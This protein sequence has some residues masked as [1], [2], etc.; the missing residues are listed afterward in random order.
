MESTWGIIVGDAFFKG[1]I[2]MDIV[3]LD[4]HFRRIWRSKLSLDSYPLDLKQ[5][6]EELHED[7]LLEYQD[8]F[9]LENQTG[10]KRLCEDCNNSTYATQFCEFCIRNYLIQTFDKWDSGNDKINKLIQ[11]TQ[12]NVICP[13]QVVEWIPYENFDNINLLDQGGFSTVFTA[14]WENGYFNEWNSITKSLERR[15]EPQQIVLKQLNSSTDDSWLNEKRVQRLFAEAVIGGMRPDINMGIP[16]KYKTLM[17]QCWDADPVKRPD[18]LKIWQREIL[19]ISKEP[20]FL[21]EDQKLQSRMSTSCILA[22]FKNSLKPINTSPETSNIKSM[23]STYGIIVGDAFFKGQ[24]TTDIVRLDKHFRRIWRSKLS[25]DSYPLDLKQLCEEL[26]KEFRNDN[27]LKVQEKEYLESKLLEYQDKFNLENQ[28]GVKRLC[29]DCNNST[30]ATQFCEFCIRNYLMQ[31]FDKWDSGNDKIN[32]IIQE[33]QKN[34][35]CPY[36]VV[37]WIP[38]ENFDNVKMLNKGGFSTVFT[39]TWKNGY[40]NR[41]NSITKSLERRG[42]PQQIVLKELYSRKPNDSWLNEKRVQR[43]FAE[44][45]IGG[46]RPDI[47]IGIPEK[48][49][50][51]MQQCWDADPVKRPD[52]LTIW[53]KIRELRRDFIDNGNR[54]FENDILNISK[55]HIIL[56]KD[57]TLQSRMSTSCILAPFQDSSKPINVSPGQYYFI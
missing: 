14:T 56:S 1:Q 34:V 51:L 13:Y 28:T 4:K 5:L 19:N 18:T 55:D 45:V 11:E 42:E 8:K 50:I 35:V 57:Q 41:W 53:Q 23:E 20:I 25:L 22:P 44:A 47:N 29:E 39:A 38:Y 24:I 21:S 6:C 32:K 48:Y 40:F 52:T 15:G 37:E 49:K 9:N 16:E 33:T 27:S 12:E 43:L 10:V 54:F 2:T 46:M 3:R 31:N 17:Q 30:Y 26:R 36:Q 7:K